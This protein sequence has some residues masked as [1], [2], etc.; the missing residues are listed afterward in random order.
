MRII[1]RKREKDIL[2]RSFWIE[3]PQFIAIVGRRRVGKTF[4]VKEYFN[5]KFSFYATGL[6]EE[7]TTGQLRA[8]TEGL[9]AAGDTNHAIAQ[10]WFEAFLRLR[11]CLTSDEVYREPLSG[12]GVVFLDELPWLDTP[13]SEFRSALDYFWNSWASS[14]ADLLLIV[15]GSA[16]SWMVKHLLDNHGGFYNRVTKR[17]HLMPFSLLECEELLRHNGIYLP[18]SQLIELYM[19]FGGIPYYLD[20]LD[21]RLSLVQNVDELCFKPSGD[22]KNACWNKEVLFANMLCI[23]ATRKHITG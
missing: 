21:E 3:R 15:C 11:Q 13:R 16:T 4:L 5:G 19:I 12:K 9:V 20:L 23:Q 17:I 22:F 10:D 18:R 14:Q 6:S 1:G 7:K 8:F 2:A